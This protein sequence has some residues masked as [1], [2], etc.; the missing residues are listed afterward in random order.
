MNAMHPTW[1]HPPAIGNTLLQYGM[2][3]I[4]AS[5]QAVHHCH[6]PTDALSCNETEKNKIRQI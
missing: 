1:Q 4:H 5:G 6:L 3:C 2:Q